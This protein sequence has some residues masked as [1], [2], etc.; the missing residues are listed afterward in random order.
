MTN[1][2]L[3]LA[4]LGMLVGVYA[5]AMPTLTRKGWRL[6]FASF[7]GD[8]DEGEDEAFVTPFEMPRAT[9]MPVTLT[10]PGSAPVAEVEPLPPVV[11]IDLTEVEDDPTLTP[12]FEEVLAEVQAAPLAALDAAPV[13]ASEPKLVLVHTQPVEGVPTPEASVPEPVAEE[14]QPDAAAPADDSMLSLFAEAADAGKAPSKIRE[15]V[16][17]VSIT[18]LQEE[19]RKLR[20]I[21]NNRAA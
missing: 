19:V 1:I 3:L 8:A 12:L 4:V 2:L 11:S 5:V 13:D 17:D 7:F 10:L 9:E 14:P 6:P 16:G 15:A 21:L 18:D 20:E